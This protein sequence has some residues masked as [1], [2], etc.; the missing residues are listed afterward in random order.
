MRFHSLDSS[1]GIVTRLWGERTINHDL[2]PGTGKRFLY[3]P[4]CPDQFWGPLNLL[5]KG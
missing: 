2:I 1:D 4:K 3:S 5:F